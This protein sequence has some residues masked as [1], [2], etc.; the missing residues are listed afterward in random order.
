MPPFVGDLDSLKERSLSNMST[1][2]LASVCTRA[3]QSVVFDPKWKR[4]AKVRKDRAVEK[5]RVERRV[6]EG[7]AP[8]AEGGKAASPRKTRK[9][10][11]KA[12]PL[13]RLTDLEI[14]AIAKVRAAKDVEA[15]AKFSELREL[16][17]DEGAADDEVL[18][19][20][21]A[22]AYY[23]VGELIVA[24]DADASVWRLLPVLAKRFI[25]IG[26]PDARKTELFDACHARAVPE[27]KKAVA[28][29][30]DLT[31]DG[32]DIQRPVAVKARERAALRRE[33]EAAVRR[34][35]DHALAALKRDEAAVRADIERFQRRLVKLG[36]PSPD[37]AVVPPWCK[38]TADRGDAHGKPLLV[39]RAA[40]RVQ[41]DGVKRTREAAAETPEAR[42]SETLR[43]FERT[44]AHLADFQPSW[45]STTD[46]ALGDAS[47][48]PRGYEL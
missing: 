32:T 47:L 41:L 4:R 19:R 5:H 27:I 26:T 9:T 13:G 18:R 46:G 17:L 28:L 35:C 12:E 15:A 10:K 48:G 39:Q 11:K 22:N 21:M 14:D 37:L 16:G 29:H 42:A 24:G 31:L 43:S 25:V 20:E 34:A 8:L 7:Q 45:A 33:V 6:Y 40:L 38:W 44:F 30:Y 1:R 23:E 2:Q 3:A 36:V